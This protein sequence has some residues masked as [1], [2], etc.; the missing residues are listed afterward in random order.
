MCGGRDFFRN[1]RRSR[2]IGGLGGSIASEPPEALGLSARCDVDVYPTE[3]RP[4]VVGIENT[5]TVGE[6]GNGSTGEGSDKGSAGTGGG[7]DCLNLS[8]G[9]MRA[10]TVLSSSLSVNPRSASSSDESGYAS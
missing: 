3:L 2:C 7:G 8:C 10:V 4:L 6:R 1:L 5:D 9:R